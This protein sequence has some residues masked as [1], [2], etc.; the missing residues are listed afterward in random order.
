MFP[1][2]PA[3][4]GNLWSDVKAAAGSALGSQVYSVLR[5]VVPRVAE[6]AGERI[7]ARVYAGSRTEYGTGRRNRDA[8]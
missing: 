4:A 1:S 6:R 2:A 5:D 7:R 8:G 3:V